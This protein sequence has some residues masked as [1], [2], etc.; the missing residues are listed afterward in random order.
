MANELYEVFGG[1]AMAGKT[2]HSA[3]KNTTKSINKGIHDMG[4][5]VGSVKKHFN[6]G[7]AK[8]LKEQI[9]AE[10]VRRGLME[11]S[12]A[13]RMMGSMLGGYGGEF[14]GSVATK[15]GRTHRRSKQHKNKAVRLK[16]KEEF[17]AAKLA[18]DKGD[19]GS[20]AGRAYGRHL[21]A[22]RAGAA[23]GSF[24][25]VYPEIVG[26]SYGAA[27][28]K[29]TQAQTAYTKRKYRYGDAQQ[30]GTRG[31]PKQQGPTITLKNRS[32]NKWG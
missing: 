21:T 29:A 24:I 7:M 23:I 9:E 14:V 20:K 3:K 13:V 18:Y 4:K 10:M 30:T 8:G 32:G 1:L 2:I 6:S 19:K 11:V 17:A 26:K 25:G 16:S 5:A 27:K 22:T 15:M 12:G 31:A 28:Y